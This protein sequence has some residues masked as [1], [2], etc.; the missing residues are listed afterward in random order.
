MKYKIDGKIKIATLE[1]YNG[2]DTKRVIAQLLLHIKA[3]KEGLPSMAF[4]D[5]V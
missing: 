5:V 2:I 3:L 1:M 4:G